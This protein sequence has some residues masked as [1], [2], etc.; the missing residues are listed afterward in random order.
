MEEKLKETVLFLSGEIE[1]LKNGNDQ[2]HNFLGFGS[3][4]YSLY[5]FNLWKYTKSEEYEL[6]AF[7]EFN[8]G[9]N[10]LESTDYRTKFSLIS[11]STGVAWLHEYF[12]YHN[13]LEKQSAVNDFFDQT[14]LELSKEESRKNKFD[15]FYGILGYGSYY[16][17][18]YRNEK[19]TDIY[20]KK[21]VDIL[22]TISFTTDTG[23]YWFSDT[24]QD[25]KNSINLGMAHGIP[26]ILSFL[27]K[28]YSFTRYDKA[29]VLGKSC[30]QWLLNFK[31]NNNN[32]KV[33]CFPYFVDLK[34]QKPIPQDTRLAWCYGDLSLAYAVFI[35]GKS[36]QDQYLVDSALDVLFHCVKRKQETCFTGI[37]DRGFCHGT[38]GVF[39]LFNNIYRHTYDPLFKNAA[40]YWLIKTLG[41]NELDISKFKA[42]GEFDGK[43]N[44]SHDLGLINGYLGIN[45]ALMSE[46]NKKY[47]QWEEIFML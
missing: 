13:F 21:L 32:N 14:L 25:K 24:F 34:S 38:S 4:A 30:C 20:L 44:Y 15:L 6:K 47:N 41:Q 37:L 11:G 12:V 16:L 39:Y 36:T 28:V 33:S 2:A 26:S 23:S 42:Y 1:L 35:F 31:N 9:Y 43:V 8:K 10:L 3:L 19:R 22:E 40:D 17:M 5:Y 29:K 46:N 27:A 7:E 18:R 45:L